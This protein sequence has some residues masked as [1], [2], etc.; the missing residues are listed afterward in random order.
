MINPQKAV[1]WYKSRYNTIGESDYDIYEKVKRIYTKDK[2]GN[3]Y[4]YPQNPFQMPA[5]QIVPPEEEIEKN[6]NPGL[7]I[8]GFP[9]NIIGGTSIQVGAK[10]APNE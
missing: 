9:V 1:N 6:T 2:N 7:I 10:V 5:S 3:E 4:Q 8:R